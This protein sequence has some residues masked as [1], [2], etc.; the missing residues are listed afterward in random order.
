[1]VLFGTAH[2]MPMPHHT[3]PKPSTT[4]KTVLR[5]EGWRVSRVLTSV[6]QATH[7]V[8]RLHT[9]PKIQITPTTGTGGLPLFRTVNQTYTHD[10]VIYRR[11]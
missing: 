7:A 11:G 1:M 3:K 4:Y 2:S 5:T 6:H 10:Y 8:H 9:A